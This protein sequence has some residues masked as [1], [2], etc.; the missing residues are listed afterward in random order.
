MA[1]TGV[2]GSRQNG[3]D[4]SQKSTTATNDETDGILENPKEALSFIEE[5]MKKM[6]R[7]LEQQTAP[8]Y[9]KLEAQVNAALKAV[10]K[11]RENWLSTP[12]KM[13]P[14]EERVIALEEAVK[15]GFQ[16]ATRQAVSSLA[17]PG[18]GVRPI[19]ASVAAP[20]A[21]KTAFRIRIAGSEMMQPQKL[22]AVAKEHIRGAYAV[23]SMRSN[24]TEVFVQIASQRDAALNMPQPEPFKIETRLS[25]PSGRSATFNKNS[26]RK[27]SK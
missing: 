14:M 16:G 20:Q 8:S 1:S 2:G 27:R 22:L 7:R 3:S 9:V 4:A 23:R 11:H 26:R 6:K 24:D 18:P 25:G 12:A 10:D 13:T 17:A 21:T 19:Y 15:K 5:V